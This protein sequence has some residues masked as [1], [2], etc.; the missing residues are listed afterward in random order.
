MYDS[1]MD[2]RVANEEIQK[3]TKKAQS[4]HLSICPIYEAT[5]GGK[6]DMEIER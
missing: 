6:L 2:I 4:N 3:K 5:V 1:H